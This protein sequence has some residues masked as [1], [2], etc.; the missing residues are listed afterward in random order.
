MD[1]MKLGNAPIN[2]ARYILKLAQDGDNAL[3]PMQVLKL[4]Y[5]SHG[6]QLGL[7]GRPLVNEPI[8]AW[9]YGPVVPSVYHRYKRFGSRFIDDIPESLPG[10]FDSSEKSVMKQVFKGYGGR[11]GSAYR[12]DA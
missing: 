12:L 5:I 6:W 10:V 1:K 4:V 2:V 9:Q 8:E 7:H 11:S 3:T